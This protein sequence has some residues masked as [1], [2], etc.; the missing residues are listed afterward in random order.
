MLDLCGAGLVLTG[1]GARLG[2]LIDIAD[3]VLHKPLRMAFPSPIA[4][5][6]A[7]LAEPEFSTVVGMVMYGHRARLAR[8]NHDDGWG[9]KLKAFFKK[10]A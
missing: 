8:N 3:S 9:A 1:G 10:G 4:K 6:P 2:G 5:M 7:E